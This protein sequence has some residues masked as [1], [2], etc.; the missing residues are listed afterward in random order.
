MVERNLKRLIYV[1][2]AVCLLTMAAATAAR[3]EDNTKGL[4]PVE[5]MLADFDLAHRIVR[6]SQL[7]P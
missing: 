2:I 3:A 1:I 4:L 7:N 5:E 6:K